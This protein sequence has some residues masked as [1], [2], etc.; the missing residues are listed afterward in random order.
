MECSGLTDHPERFQIQGSLE[1]NVFF[2]LDRKR[3]HIMLLRDIESKN[4]IDGH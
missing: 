4:S 3:D 2:L 1:W